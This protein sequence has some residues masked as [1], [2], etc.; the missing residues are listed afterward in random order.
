[1]QHILLHIATIALDAEVE[2]APF[3]TLI[4]NEIDFPGN[5]NIR[6]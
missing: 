6:N 4:P 1:M 5:D 3:K 2:L